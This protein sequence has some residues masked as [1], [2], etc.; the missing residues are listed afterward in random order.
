MVKSIRLKHIFMDGLHFCFSPLAGAADGIC[1]EINRPVASSLKQMA[2]DNIR[3][4]FTPFTGASAGIKKELKHRKDSS[5]SLPI[6]MTVDFL[7]FDRSWVLHPDVP[8]RCAAL[9]HLVAFAKECVSERFWKALRMNHCSPS[10]RPS[11]LTMS[12]FFVSAIVLQYRQP[13]YRCC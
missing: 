6:L 3:L 5:L 4:Y 13:C 2:K 12:R 11:V 8:V 9:R 1:A 7:K 10:P